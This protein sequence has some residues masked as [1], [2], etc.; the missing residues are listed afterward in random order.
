ME[1]KTTS[2][3]QT[4]MKNINQTNDKKDEKNIK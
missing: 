4:L 3:P 2:D 1:R